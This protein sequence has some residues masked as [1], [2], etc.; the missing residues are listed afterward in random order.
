MNLKLVTKIGLVTACVILVF[1]IAIG[2]TYIKMNDINQKQEMVKMYAQHSYV[3]E[4]LKQHI[5]G[6]TANIALYIISD[7]ANHRDQYEQHSKMAE[8]I[9]N[10]L[11]AMSQGKNKELVQQI[12]ATDK[13][14]ND[15]IHNQILPLLSQG[16]KD[17]ASMVLM[18][19]ANPLAD[20]MTKNAEDYSEAM[21]NLLDSQVKLTQDATGTTQRNSVIYGI[22]ALALGLAATLYLSKIVKASVGNLL[23]GARAVAAGDLTNEIRVTSNDELGEIARAFNGMMV[24]IREIISGI[25]ASAGSLSASSDE[26]SHTIGA[27]NQSVEEISETVTNLSAST[28]QGSDNSRLATEVAIKMN[29]NA[30][31]SGQSVETVITKMGIIEDTVASSSSIIN[32][33]KDHSQNINQMLDVINAIAEQTNLLALNA[34]IEAARAG[35]NGRGFAVV[36]EE[37]R[38][39]AEESTGAVKDI[40]KIIHEVTQGADSS[41]DAMHNVTVQVKDGVQSV[42]D[43]GQKIRDIITQIEQSTRSMTEVAASYQETG[44]GLETMVSNIE[45]TSA[46]FQ[47]LNATAS[48]LARMASE[49]HQMV[50]KFKVS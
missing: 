14:Y 6:Q 21:Q 27:I 47:I 12:Q 50:G 25:K 29:D 26:I 4:E 24:G 42:G 37:V 10:E 11:L 40:Q 17:E 15:I 35:E 23:T 16:K 1:S 48:Q 41:V 7:D 8:E 45:E 34:A 28:N 39:L 36:A 20:A 13:K 30:V 3:T 19:E 18:Q 49:L 43:V 2:S 22:I 32:Q 9:E 33:L 31:E 46:S 38:Q 44:A 5:I